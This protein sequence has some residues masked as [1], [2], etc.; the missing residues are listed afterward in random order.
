M[1]HENETLTILKIITLTNSPKKIIT[2]TSFS[3]SKE[4]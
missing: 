3:I 1:R 4:I 2:L